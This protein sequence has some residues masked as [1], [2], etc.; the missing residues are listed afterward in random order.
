MAWFN[1]IIDLAALTLWLNWTHLRLDPLA[2]T[3]AASLAGTLRRTE[4]SGPK[5]W[6]FPAALAALL[7]A[8]AWLYLQLSAVMNLSPK[9][10]LGFINIPFRGDLPLHMLIFSVLS[11]GFVLGAFYLWMLF[12]S[13]VNSGSTEASPVHKL[14]MI[15]VKWLKSWPNSL[16]LLSPFLLGGLGWL[17]LHPLLR[18]LA[19][20]PAAKSAAQLSVQAVV[21]GV[22]TYLTWK[23]LI[24]GVLLF[25]LVNAHV[26]LGNLPVWNYADATARNL[27]SPLRWL[28]LRA[29]RFDFLPL[30]A[31][32][33][34]ILLARLL[35]N[36][37]EGFYRLLPF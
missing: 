32:A 37:P 20:V 18:W 22:G 12:L 6:K 17:A 19:V 7:L 30:L 5:R 2:K 25:H 15:Q 1:L 24:L 33:A 16:K 13:T 4:A 14:V 36:P 10:R 34:V 29:G 35:E 27:L 23:Y 11:F 21:I 26:Y 28:P 31:M 8:R 3:T 9:L